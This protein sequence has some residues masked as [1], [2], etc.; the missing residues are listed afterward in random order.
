MIVQRWLTTAA[1]PDRTV[2]VPHSTLR[3]VLERMTYITLTSGEASGLCVRAC[4]CVCVY[5]YV[6]VC[7][8]VL[9]LSRFRFTSPS[10]SLRYIC[11]C[12]QQTMMSDEC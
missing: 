8:R 3:F 4:V 5:I 11:G 9:Q 10:I 6:C 2:S 1:L 7:A 12:Q